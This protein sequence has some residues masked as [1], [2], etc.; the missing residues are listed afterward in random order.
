MTRFV[1]FMNFFG[2]QS[3]VEKHQVA[4]LS[5]KSRAVGVAGWIRHTDIKIIGKI[6][7]K[8]F[9]GSGSFVVFIIRGFP[10]N[11]KFC[12]F[13]LAINHKRDMNP[14]SEMI[15]YPATIRSASYK[16]GATAYE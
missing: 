9:T 1:V 4:H 8:V 12:S 10:I 16:L 14:F 13:G 6:E 15:F 5:V 3:A 2:G 11:I 7:V